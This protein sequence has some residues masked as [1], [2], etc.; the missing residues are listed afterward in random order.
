MYYR[1]FFALI[2]TT[3]LTGSLLADTL[4]P[5]QPIQPITLEPVKP[6]GVNLFPASLKMT[7][8]NSGYKVDGLVF[9]SG[10]KNQRGTVRMMVETYEIV[11]PLLDNQRFVQRKYSRSF[12]VSGGV[13]KGWYKYFSIMIPHS[14]IPFEGYI[15]VTVDPRNTIKELNE[16]DNTGHL[17][18]HG[19]Y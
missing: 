2:I 6:Y 15:K 1:I 8:K 16:K 5:V 17:G 4:S 12:L 13:E 11:H 18:K 9:N 7:Y 10:N 14:K 3:I 19:V